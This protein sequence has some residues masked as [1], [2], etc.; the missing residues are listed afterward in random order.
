MLNKRFSE[1]TKITNP[2]FIHAGPSYMSLW[3]LP[4]DSY[5]MTMIARE[6]EVEKGLTVLL[7]ENERIMRHGFTVT[8]LKRN[9]KR[10]LRHYERS[11]KERDK[12]N[13]RNFYFS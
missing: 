2:P 13:S 5:T 12:I 11:F 4:V 9:K 8:E 6:G 1:L 7:R 3:G 10:V